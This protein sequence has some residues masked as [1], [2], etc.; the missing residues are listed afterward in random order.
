MISL[1]PHHGMCIGQFKGYG[2]SEEFVRNMTEVISELENSPDVQ[3]KLVAGGDSICSSC[4]HHKE[5]GCASGQKVMD[6]DKKVLLFCALKENEVLTWR[7]FKSLVKQHILAE[8]KLSEVCCN[9]S[10][11][12]LCLECQGFRY[13]KEKDSLD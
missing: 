1:R 5:D 7:E 8:N 12:S 2:Y 13:A 10:W 11:L 6:Y 4:P 3:I 9:C